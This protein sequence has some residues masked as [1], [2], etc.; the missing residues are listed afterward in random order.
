MEVS[1]CPRPRKVGEIWF[2]N[3]Y[4]LCEALNAVSYTYT[5]GYT[6]RGNAFRMLQNNVDFRENAS[7]FIFQVMNGSTDV[8]SMYFDQINTCS[9]LGINYSELMPSGYYYLN[10]SY[11]QQVA[12]AIASTNG[13]N[14]T[15]STNSSIHVY[16]H[17]CEYA[18]P[19]QM[20]FNAIVP[21]GW[22]T[23]SLKGILD[24]EN[25]VNS[26]D[27]T[28]TDWK[29]V[30]TEKLSW[31]TDG[32]VILPTIQECISYTTKPYAEEGLSRFKS[33]QWVSGMPSSDFER[34]LY[35]VINNTYILP[36]YSD[37]T[38]EDSDGDGL[39]DINDPAPMTEKNYGSSY[40]TMNDE[41]YVKILQQCLEYLGYL[42]MDGNS[43][44]T[45]GG[46]TSAATQLYQVNHR[47]YSKNVSLEITEYV[48]VSSESETGRTIMLDEVT[49]YSIIREALNCG[50]EAPNDTLWGTIS[51]TNSYTFFKN[52][53]IPQSV[54]LEEVNVSLNYDNP[55]YIKSVESKLS[56][57]KANIYI[58]DLTVPLEGMLRLGAQEFH[59][60]HYTCNAV[61][62]WVESMGSNYLTYTN[63]SKRCRKNR[64]DFAWLILNVANDKR[65]DVKKKI[66]GTR[67]FTILT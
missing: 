44:G 60:H 47:M 66:A 25:G 2:T 31:D 9:I 30:M 3:Y 34:Y 26:D 24:S 53:F 15:Y 16:N 65:Y 40:I 7:K 19:P 32:T 58:Y 10:P 20:V 18:A 27:D 39:L 12:D 29:E 5:S 23:I 13:M 41:Q 6:D 50:F 54:P 28:L 14:A 43:Y 62:S 49:F 1:I 21:T 55:V 59:F 42:N 48:D 67:F 51:V 46:L 36:I 22:K 37:P 11:G 52:K 63:S 38:E 56:S 4:A 57:E 35:Y 61:N 17:I 8:G 45:F 64:S 33:E